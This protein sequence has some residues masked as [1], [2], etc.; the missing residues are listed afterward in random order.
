MKIIQLILY[1][2]SALFM[3]SIIGVLGPWDWINAVIRPFS[4]D[5]LPD[6]PLVQYS[7]KG[8]LLMTFWIGVLLAIAVRRPRQNRSALMIIGWMLLSAGIIS[9]PLG[10]IY[11]VPTFFYY[12]ALAAMVIGVLV[13]FY[14]AR[15]A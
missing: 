12:D 7:I 11:Q 5:V 2:T 6:Q 9:I 8:F 4:P 15:Q 13:F 3:L 10:V 14:E 1:A